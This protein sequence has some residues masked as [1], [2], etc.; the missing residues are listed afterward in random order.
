MKLKKIALLTFLSAVV[1]TTGVFADSPL[2]STKFSDAYMD[3]PIVMTADKAKGV[4][5]NELMAYLASEYNPVD[6]KMA[7]INRIGWKI[8]GR[9]NAKLFME[10]LKT[11]HG[12]KNETRFYKKGR[13]DELLSMAYLKAM[14]NY[15]EVD[16]A[17]R[18]AER[19]LKKNKSK[20][21]TFMLVAGL[22]KAQKAMDG[23]WCEVYQITN[24]VR[25]NQMLMND[26]RT[27]AVGIIYKYM[28]I[29]GDEC[30]KSK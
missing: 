3:E 14:D 1:L 18:Y 19:A 21:R 28:D 9:T 17:I 23:N 29:Y 27:K 11:N 6:V 30:E 12:Y 8:S 10:Y 20:S 13:A 4:L 22:I 25:V 16:D 5:N 2:T 26:M 15:F 7:V 24:R